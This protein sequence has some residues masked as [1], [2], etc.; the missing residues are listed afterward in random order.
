M[1]RLRKLHTQRSSQ[2]DVENEISLVDVELN[3][4]FVQELS[5]AVVV[6]VVVV[7]E[8]FDRSLIPPD[9]VSVAFLDLV[10]SSTTA[11]S[12]HDYPTARR[13]HHILVGPPYIPEYA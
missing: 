7:R 8:T 10:S 5:D 1:V 9:A 4:C 13:P 11:F 2:I 3:V 12:I 6:V